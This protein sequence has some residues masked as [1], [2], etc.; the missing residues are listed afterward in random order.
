MTYGWVAMAMLFVVATNVRADTAIQM[1]ATTGFA[2]DS[3]L[4]RSFTFSSLEVPGLVTGVTVSVYFAKTD[5]ETFV[6]LSDPLPSGTPYFNEI[7]M[8]LEAPSGQIVYLIAE[9]SFDNGSLG[10]RGVITFDQSAGQ[11]VNY[12]IDTPHE[13]TFQPTGDLDDFLG[14]TAAGTWT[15]HIE[16]TVGADG[17][18]YYSSALTV[19]SEPVPEPATGML[20]LSGLGALVLVRRRFC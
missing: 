1:D 15:L 5:G 14:L 17:L 11:V 10:F 8:Y 7:V 9:G 13:G 20:L 19:N 2:D 3:V 18:S 6:D 16:D 4:T 12:D